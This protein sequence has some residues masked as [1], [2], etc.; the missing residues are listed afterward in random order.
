LKKTPAKQQ[1]TKYPLLLKSPAKQYENIFTF[2]YN[3][4][5]KKSPAKQ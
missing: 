2:C 3:I 5:Q 1:H 4:I